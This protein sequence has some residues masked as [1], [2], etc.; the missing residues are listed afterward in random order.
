MTKVDFENEGWTEI[1]PGRYKK[2]EYILHY[3][4][5]SSNEDIRLVIRKGSWYP[6][7]AVFLGKCNSVEELRTIQKLV[8]PEH[9]NIYGEETRYS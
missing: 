3:G 5:W 2:L 4:P 7:E 6:E 8:M 9:H 1:F